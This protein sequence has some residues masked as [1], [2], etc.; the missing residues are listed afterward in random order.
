MRRVAAAVAALLLAV[1][2]VPA[3]AQVE[4]PALAS[5]R[6]AGCD[7]LVCGDITALVHPTDFGPY[8]V[9]FTGSITAA[10]A[11]FTTPGFGT[12]LLGA[13]RIAPSPDLYSQDW[14]DGAAVG[15][16]ITPAD[17]TVAFVE[18][19]GGRASDPALTGAFLSYYNVETQN[20][21]SITLQAVPTIT[22]PEPATLALVGTGLA[23]L[24]AARRRRRA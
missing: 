7:A 2:A 1:P 16:P 8:I 11:Y 17:P 4:L 15:G 3:A 18:S 6:F 10:P 21:T 20:S 9:R 19:F 5:Y 23:G 13:L 22:N 14:F 12:T 24:I